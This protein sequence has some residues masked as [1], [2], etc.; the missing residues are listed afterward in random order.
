MPTHA[1]AAEYRCTRSAAGFQLGD[2]SVNR[3]ANDGVRGALGEPGGRL[4]DSAHASLCLA[5]DVPPA[6]ASVPNTVTTLPEP[7][8]VLHTHRSAGFPGWLRAQTIEHLRHVLESFRLSTP[9]L[10]TEPSQGDF[11]C[12]IEAT[13]YAAAAI[14]MS[15]RHELRS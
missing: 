9:H 7:L 8:H 14:V 13:L 3:E 15:R 1:S 10:S 12:A 6:R 4:L 2:P 5:D 11:W